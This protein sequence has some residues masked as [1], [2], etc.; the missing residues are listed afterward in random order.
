MTEYFSTVIGLG[1]LAAA[2]WF[3]YDTLRAREHAIR[4]ARQLCKQ[5]HV[6]LLD[7]TVTLQRVWLQRNRRGRLNWLRTYQFEFSET[8]ATRLTGI[9]SLNGHE[10]HI[11]ELPGYMERTII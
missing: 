7:Q 11:L 1:L 4:F 2:A 9:V 8:G 6:Q 5:Y 10:L 3:W